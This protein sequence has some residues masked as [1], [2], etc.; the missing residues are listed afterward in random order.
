MTLLRAQIISELAVP[1]ATASRLLEGLVEKVRSFGGRVEDLSARGLVAAFGLEPDEDAPRRAANAGL[2]IMKGVERERLDGALPGELSVGVALDV[3]AAARGRRGRVRGHRRG[4]Q[5]PRLAHSRRARPLE[6]RRRL[7]LS[8]TAAQFLGRHYEIVRQAE[9]GHVVA[10]LIGRAPADVKFAP[11][12]F[13]GRDR[14]LALLQGLL[15][16]AAEGRGQLVTIVGNPGIGKSRLAHEFG[17][18]LAPDAVTLLKGQC[19]SYGSSTPYHL[20]LDMLRDVC[21]VQ[22]GDHPEE[23]DAKARAVLERVGAS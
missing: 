11:T 6:R 19:V 18:G 9:R 12:G 13:V 15:E 22:E 4:G 2:A 10:R 5:G 7:A 14:E 21:G 1:L 20:I 3:D 17:R 23:I 16:H 8:E